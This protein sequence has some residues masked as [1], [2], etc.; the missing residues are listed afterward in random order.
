LARDATAATTTRKVIKVEPKPKSE[1]DKA[2]KKNNAVG[3]SEVKPN[4]A[5][6]SGTETKKTGSNEAESSKSVEVKKIETA[7]KSKT[8]Q[9]TNNNSAAKNKNASQTPGKS[10]KKNSNAKP[11]ETRPRKV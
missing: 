7:T 4:A 11:Q 2:A 3:K 8:E 10:E 9:K 5:T 6:P 1:S